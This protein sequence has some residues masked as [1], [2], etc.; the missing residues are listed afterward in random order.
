MWWQEQTEET[1][2]V[3]IIMDTTRQTFVKQSILDESAYPETPVSYP[4]LNR[5]QD[6]FRFVGG[7]V[8]QLHQEPA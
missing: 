5:P 6:Y 2:F 3:N 1:L 8:P 7:L 4:K